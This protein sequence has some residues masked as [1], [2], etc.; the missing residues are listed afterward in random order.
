MGEG[1]EGSGPAAGLSR[2]QALDDAIRRVQ[3]PP[4]YEE[5]VKRVFARSVNR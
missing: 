2:R 3:V 1:P 4:E 5:I